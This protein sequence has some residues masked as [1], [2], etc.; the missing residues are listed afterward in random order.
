MRRLV[1]LA[2]TAL[3][4]LSVAGGTAAPAQP[5]LV[6]ATTRTAW[7]DD[8]VFALTPGHAPRSLATGSVPGISAD[9]RSL[10]YVAGSPEAPALWVADAGGGGARQVAVLD[11]APWPRAN[12]V[13][14][15]DGHVV[16]LPTSAGVDL[17]DVTTAKTHALKGVYEAAFSPDG[18]QL[19]LIGGGGLSVAAADGAGAHVIAT[20]LTSGTAVA[21]SPDGVWIAATSNDH[22]S[23]MGVVHPDG[24]GER[25]FSAGNFG[26]GAPAWSHDGRLAWVTAKQLV[27]ASPTGSARRVGPMRFVGAGPPAP[28]VWTNGDRTIVTLAPKGFVFTDVATGHEQPVAAPEPASV[29][30]SG[31]GLIGPKL[32]Y[33]AHAPDRD[34][35]IATIREDGSGFR[36]LTRNTVDDLRPAWSPDGRSIVFAR[37]S[38]KQHGIYAMRPDGTAVRR[39]THADDTAPVVS[40]DGKSIAF[41]RGSS[42]RLMPFAAGASRQ[43][44]KTHFALHQLA[45]APDGAIVFSDDYVLHR[46]DVA[47]GTVTTIPLAFDQ[48][49][50]ANRPVVAPDGASVAF[51]GYVNGHAFRDPDAYGVY[52]ANANGSGVRK[53]LGELTAAPTGWSS[54]GRTLAVTDGTRLM[55]VPAAGGKATTLLGRFDGFGGGRTTWG[56]FRP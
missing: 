23:I 54:D 9:G 21:W 45:W 26:I 22:G 32:L 50:S 51:E 34:L 40:P 5:L 38:A 12:A 17:V 33:A 16:L 35:E 25:T 8:H 30:T 48:G 20:D 11:G 27:V 47:T 49:S 7:S 15:P 24:S 3:A 6:I 46:L 37:R 28:P 52:V 55:L 31:V 10:A 39:L 1:L 19:A 41:A 2:V 4:L 14:S 42:I 44:V 43:L 53:V 29:V 36:L 18:S 56:A 13:W